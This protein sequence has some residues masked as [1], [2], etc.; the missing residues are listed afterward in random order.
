MFEENIINITSEW[1]LYYVFFL[2]EAR[3][4][5]QDPLSHVTGARGADCLAGMNFLTLNRMIFDQKIGFSSR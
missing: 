2:S 5:E 1:K 4:R 3:A